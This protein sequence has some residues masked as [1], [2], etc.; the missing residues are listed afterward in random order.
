[1]TM[2]SSAVLNID[3]LSL[4]FPAYRSNVQA[5]N[6]VS[7]HVNPGEIVGVVGE[8]GSGKSVTAMLSLRLLPERS[9]RITSGSLSLLGRDMLA[10]PEKQLLQIRGRDAA[11]IFQEPMTA[12]NPT[13]RI[14]RQM[15]D[16]IIH[17]QRLSQEQA[18]AK[19]IDLL[20]D[21]H[22]ADPEQ[23][24]Q[25]YPFE[26]S[27]GM[28]QR[29]MIALAFSCDPQLLIADEPT[30]AL[31]VTVQRQVLLL[32]REKA[33][34]RGTAILLITHDMA[35]VSQFCDRVYVMY[36]GAVVE[37]GSTAQVMLDPQHPYT[38]GLLSGLPEQVRPGEPLLTIPGQVPNL[39]HLPG[40]CTFRERCSQA[41]AVCAQRPPLHSI[42]ASQQHK[43][44]C[45]LAA[46]ESAQ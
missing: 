7:L 38:R 19:A 27:G 18:R 14:G 37:Q 13:R 28:R 17:H 44:A 34:Q 1:M 32:L 45:W 9:Y 10:T 2:S 5:L 29:V 46:P 39:A 25:A 20:R 15:L 41:M 12:L 31:D 23:V 35:V 3:N 33:R 43:S 24:L 36:T 26:L 6:G 42:N 30:T 4:E 21:M 16:V 40:G 8:S 22:I 11:M